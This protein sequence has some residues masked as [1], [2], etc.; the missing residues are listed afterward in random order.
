VSKAT[1]Q[2]KL[3]AK[4]PSVA[5]AAAARAMA[6]EESRLAVNLPVI[7][8][9]GLKAKA[10]QSGLSIKDYVLELLKRDGIDVG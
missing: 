10:A 7:A 5:A 2:V 9:R 3:S 8:H 1:K 6:S 4:R